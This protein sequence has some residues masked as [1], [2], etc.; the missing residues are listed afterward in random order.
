[1]DLIC[2]TS[3]LL[4]SLSFLRSI[5]NSFALYF[6][7][8]CPARSEIN[9]RCLLPTLLGLICSYILLSLRTALTWIPPLCAKAEFPTNAERELG[10]RFINSLNKFKRKLN[11]QK[12]FL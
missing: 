2:E 6:I 9:T 1:M 4:N 5:P 7:L 10:T 8:L 11:H 12:Q 3:F